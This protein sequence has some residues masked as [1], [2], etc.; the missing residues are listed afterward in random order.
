MKGICL[1]LL[2]FRVLHWLFLANGQ[3]VQN[4]LIFFE[5]NLFLVETVDSRQG[6]IQRYVTV[7]M[8]LTRNG[9]ALIVGMVCQ[10]WI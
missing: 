7:K 10:C 6:L 9:Y 3:M 1:E 5:L 4:I 2:K 8:V